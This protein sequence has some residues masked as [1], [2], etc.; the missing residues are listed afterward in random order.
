MPHL[1]LTCLGAIQVHLDGTALTN[2]HSV[3][4]QGLL[5][6]LALE[7]TRPPP[8][9]E[10]LMAL[11]W[12]DDAPQSAQRSLRQ[13]L[14]ALRRTLGDSDNATH[15]PFLL[16]TRQTIQFNPR[17]QVTLDVT[18]FLQQV[19][20]GHLA[21]AAA[22]YRA[23]LLTGM[24]TDCAPFE[25]WLR[26]TREYLH[27]LA[28]NALDQLTQQR[29][30]AS[31]YAGAVPYAR[32][33]L[34]LEPWRE[35]A[36]RQAMTALALSG[37]RSAALA[38][39]ETCR[40]ILTAELGV[41]TDEE[42]T[43]LYEQI[44]AGKL[45]G[46]RAAPPLTAHS[47]EI[48]SE[49]NVGEETVVRPTMSQAVRHNLPSQPT[50]FIGRQADLAQIITRLNDQGCRL[51]TIVGPGGMGKTRLALQTAQTIL[52]V[53]FTL[54]DSEAGST[55]YPKFADGVFFVALAGV[56]SPDLLVS[57]IAAT[58]DFTPYGNGTPQSQLLGH[59]R[60]KTIL[61]V[62]DNFEHLLDGVDVIT[63]LLAAA[64]GVK[65]LTT[66]REALNLYEEWLHPLSGMSFPGDEDEARRESN[67]QL[68]DYTA[69]QLFVQ[70]AQRMKPSF[71]LT[72]EGAAVVR[73]CHLV[74]GMPLGIEMAT[75]WLKHFPCEQIAKEI[76]RNL[77]FLATTLR[78]VPSHH[79]SIR[80]V[81]E[82]SW[83]LLSV[84]EQQTLQQLAVFRGGF[85][86]A[87]A[88]QVAGAN[89]PLLVSLAE[90]SLVQPTPSGRYQIHEL[91]RQFAE[92][93]L[94]ALLQEWSAV[95]ERH[96]H[97]YLLFLQQHQAGLEGR[98]SAETVT[99]IEE[100]SKTSARPG[101]G[102]SAIRR[103]M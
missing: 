58:L 99:I 61:L 83:H 71:D 54:A 40:R 64:L 15:E 12:T 24:T 56:A 1:A 97:Y 66:S 87:A 27:N 70:R 65:V 16:V 46:Q 17:S 60:P 103:W 91:L 23:D 84:A 9:R 72:S 59:L 43:Q 5:A 85:Q 62:L 7:A 94:Q 82:H 14:Y 51:L 3:K 93:K 63:S 6:Y 36:H 41:E 10:T 39:Y 28:L 19:Q 49:P 100:E 69:V 20:Q 11:F 73:I 47:L 48:T 32:R 30:A 89:F 52:D 86:L 44:R 75:S 37:D 68:S 77:D 90:K 50:P 4:V 25:E 79:R 13:A 96:A 67:A 76:E 2:F 18:T 55:A 29:L 101:T 42:T 88:Q 74:G 98:Q 102:C 45:R 26:G 38:Q 21:Q 92:E 8:T 95:Q 33:Q 22:L 53:G 81:F 31:D 80:A 78:N 57:T 34:T 35:E